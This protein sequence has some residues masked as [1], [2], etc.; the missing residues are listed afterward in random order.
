MP[1][2]PL[3][4]VVL[5]ACC[6]GSFASSWTT[7]DDRAERGDPLEVM[8]RVEVS[9]DGLDGS[10]AAVPGPA[11][12]FDG[13]PCPSVADCY[14]VTDSFFNRGRAYLGPVGGTG[15]VA[16]RFEASHV[17]TPGRIGSFFWGGTYV[18]DP[19][20]AERAYPAGL[21]AWPDLCPPGSGLGCLGLA[22]AD[23]D[24]VLNAAY[25]RA[26]ERLTP[27][28]FAELR[29]EQRAWIGERD[30]TCRAA[31]GASVAWVAEAAEALCLYDQTRRRRYGLQTWGD[32]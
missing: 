2:V 22:Y 25:A 17:E 11:P 28:R 12:D 31:A 32:G 13:E 3:L 27:E 26:R 16:V 14:D 30:A 1:V 15:Q 18:L 29:T 7:P 5:S 23:E 20:P 4:P 6:L 21:F 8:L 19:D 24:L 10:Y 9:A